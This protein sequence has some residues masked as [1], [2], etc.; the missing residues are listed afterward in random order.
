MK[1]VL[2]SLRE[3]YPDNYMRI[4]AFSF[5]RRIFSLTLKTI[6]SWV[7]KTWLLSKIHEPLPKLLSTM[8]KSIGQE[9]DR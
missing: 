7:E 1:D 6:K 9:H 5:N 8:L 2:S 4:V 3:E